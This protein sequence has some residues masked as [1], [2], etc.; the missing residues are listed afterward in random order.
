[1]DGDQTL[2]SL[3]RS[4]SRRAAPVEPCTPIAV[5]SGCAR[6]PAL[7]RAALLSRAVAAGAFAAYRPKGRFKERSRWLE[8]RAVSR[9][10]DVECSKVSTRGRVPATAA[11]VRR[12][13]RD[14]RWHL[15]PGCTPGR[16]GC[17]FRSKAS[18]CL[19]ATRAS[20]APIQVASTPSGV[21]RPAAPSAPT[22]TWRASAS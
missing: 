18:V 10:V 7:Y 20:S 5:F 14:G 9:L 2:L 19:H 13:G 11:R 8:R 4:A 3:G 16:C 22:D 6:R 12:E 1:M 21:T 17:P 15:C